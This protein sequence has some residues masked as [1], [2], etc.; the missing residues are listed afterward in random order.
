MDEDGKALLLLEGG[1]D[2]LQQ[3]QLTVTKVL[4]KW[5]RICNSE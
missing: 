1:Q 2:V 5:E 4:N 3:L